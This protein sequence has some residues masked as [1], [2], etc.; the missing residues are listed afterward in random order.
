QGGFGKFFH[1]RGLVPLD[2]QTVIRMNRDTLY[3]VAVFDLSAG[4][5]TIS[6]PNAGKRYMSMQVIDEDHFTHAV[7]YGEGRYTFPGEKVS[8]RYIGVGVRTLV[9]PT[10]PKDLEEVLTLQDAVKV[11]QN[12]PGR[13]E[14]PNW[15]EASRKKVHDALLVLGET[16]PDTKRMF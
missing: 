15:D 10:N 6:L 7:V 3:S 13:F 1:L 11:S 14:V 12:G 4:P 2:R 5:V 9:D 8:T 16:V